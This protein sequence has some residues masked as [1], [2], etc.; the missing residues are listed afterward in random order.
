MKTCSRRGV[1]LIEVLITIVI[2]AIALFALVPPFLAEGSF[3]RKG[4]R[5]TEA[6]R[7]AQ[8]V[9]RAMARVA[10]ESND[11][12]S[13]AGIVTFHGAPTC[14]GGDVTFELHPGG[15]LHQ[16]CGG[17]TSILIDGVRSQV[18]AFTP[19]Q[20]IA[21]RLVLIHLQVDHRLRTTDPNLESETLDTELFLRNG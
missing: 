6:Q 18:A 1:T 10:R 11:Y 2:S 19:S 16:H 21:K 7:D 5:Q 9:L 8:M 20:I 13:G 4:K 15:E 17:N 3:F 14:G 12:T